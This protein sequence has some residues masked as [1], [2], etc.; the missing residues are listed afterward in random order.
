MKLD[1][2]KIYIDTRFR[3]KNSKSE[4]DFS[5]EL[6]RSFNVP[7]GTTAY[8]DDIVIPVS[9]ITIDERNNNCYVAFACGGS[10]IE[11]GFVFD[12]KN[13]DGFTFATALALKL[14][15][16]V[17]GFVVVPTFACS[18]D[19]GENQLT[20]SIIDGRSASVKAFALF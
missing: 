5:I 2:Q 15:T 1:I 4:T 14:N 12:S 16:A 11:K 3:T 20:I 17:A 10:L 8:I 9:W 13:Y 7:D 18:Y 6:P 19:G